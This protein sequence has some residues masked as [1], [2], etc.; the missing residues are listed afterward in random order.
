MS[1]FKPGISWENSSATHVKISQLVARLS[2]ARQ[3]VVFAQ[4]CLHCLSKVINKFETSCCQHVTSLMEISDLSHDCPI[5]SDTELH[6][7]FPIQYLILH[8]VKYFF[9]HT[10]ASITPLV[11]LR[12]NCPRSRGHFIRSPP[13][14]PSLLSWTYCRQNHCNELISPFRK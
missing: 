4:Q 7:E 6:V 14:H 1:E 3:Q 8:P 12:M 13:P 11:G 10:F 2:Q 9:C 5:N